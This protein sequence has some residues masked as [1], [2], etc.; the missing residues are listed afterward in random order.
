[1]FTSVSQCL[2][3]NRYSMCNEW[4]GGRKGKK[5]GKKNGR[6]ERKREEGREEGRNG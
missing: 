4:E 2:L 5:E 1:M 3:S 6:K